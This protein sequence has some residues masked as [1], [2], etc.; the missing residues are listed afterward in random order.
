M[1]TNEP[2][3]LHAALAERDAALEELSRVRADL[4]ALRLA[5]LSAGE[6]E[7]QRYPPGTAPGAPPLRYVVADRVHSALGPLARAARTLFPA[8]RK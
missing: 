1:N 4:A 3:R 2:D 6:A 7:P 5:T 8:G